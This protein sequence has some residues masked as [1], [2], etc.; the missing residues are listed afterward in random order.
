VN[1]PRCICFHLV[2]HDVRKHGPSKRKIDMQADRF[3]LSFAIAMGCAISV[4]SVALSQ[5][6]RGTWEQQS[7]CTPDVW[8]LCGA[9]IPDV[10]RIVACLRRNTPQLT[11]RCR[12]VFEQGARGEGRDYG[13]GVTMVSMVAVTTGQGGTTG[14]TV[15]GLTMT[16]NKLD[17]LHL[18][19]WVQLGRLAIGHPPCT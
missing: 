1:F 4:Q 5:E 18:R 19:L 10:D 3:C 14:N 12:A 9:Q 17:R 8:R 16:T 11:D 6:Y 15:Q 13:K 2:Q 7:A